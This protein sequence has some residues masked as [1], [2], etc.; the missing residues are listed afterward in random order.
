MSSE[1]TP[2]IRAPAWV[3]GL[4][5]GETIA[6]NEPN[7]R[8][9]GYMRRRYGDGSKRTDLLEWFGGGEGGW[10]MV[11]GTCDFAA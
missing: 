4:A 5:V 1:A 3:A 9:I 2:G 8:M 7:T 11:E 10:S 6:Y